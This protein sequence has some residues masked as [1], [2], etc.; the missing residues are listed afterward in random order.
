MLV[1]RRQHYVAARV[2]D[3]SLRRLVGWMQDE[4]KRYNEEIEAAALGRRDQP[5]TLHPP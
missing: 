3:F 2:K 1:V 5:G 4:L